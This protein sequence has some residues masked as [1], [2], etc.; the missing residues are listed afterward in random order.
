MHRRDF[1]GSLIAAAVSA[2][3]RANIGGLRGVG[4][5]G[6]IGGSA[7][8]DNFAVRAGAPMVVWAHNFE[9]A[10][11][12]NQW[13]WVGGQMSP[14]PSGSQAQWASDSTGNF[15]R[16]TVPT[17]GNTSDGWIRPMGAFAAG[18]PVGTS[19]GNGNGLTTDDPAANGT[20]RKVVWNSSNTAEAYNYR[21]SYFTNPVIQVAYPYWPSIGDTGVYDGTEFWLQVKVRISS[22]RWNTG[23]PG[24]KLIF[25]DVTAQLSDLQEVVVRSVNNT[26]SGTV[27]GYDFY[28]T[29][30]LL[31][32][33]SRG[34]YNNST[35]DATQGGGDGAFSSGTS[36]EPGGPYATSCTYGGADTAGNCWEFPSGEW[37]TL[38]FHM[39]P[40]QDTSSYT[41]TPPAGNTSG[42]PFHD[43]TIEVWKC[44]V[45]DVGYTKIFEQ[46][47]LAWFYD[48]APQSGTNG[49]T[50]Q[51]HAPAF[52]EVSFSAY[53]NG[54]NSSIGWTQD[55][56]EAIFSK[57]Y[58]APPGQTAPTWW[59]SA[60]DGQ[61]TAI[62]GGGGFGSNYQNGNRLSDVAPSPPVT[63]SGTGQSSIIETWSGGTVDYVN[64]RYF[65]VAN[66]GHGDYAGNEGYVL[67]L[68]TATPSWQRFIDPTPN[69]SITYNDSP[70]ASFAKNSDGRARSMHTSAFQCYGDY[71]IW[72]PYCNSY[73]SP[74][75]GSTPYVASFNTLNSGVAAALADNTTLAWDG[76]V[77]P[78]Q[79]W[80]IIPGNSGIDGDGSTGA[81]SFGCSC[82]DRWGH[83]VYGFG[84][85]GFDRTNTYVW[86]INTLGDA[87]G[88]GNSYLL[89]SGNPYADFRWAVCVFDLRII[90][91]ADGS[92]GRLVVFDLNNVGGSGWYTVPTVSGT[93]YY[94]G[95]VSGPFPGAFYIP[96]TRQ[97][98]V[99]D[100]PNIGNKVYALNVPT[101]ADAYGRTI[102]N[103]SGVWTWTN[104]TPGGVT[105]TF[106]NDTKP[107]NRFNG[108]EDMGDGRSALVYVGGVNA[109]TYVYKIPA[110]GL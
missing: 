106:P 80:G 65:L 1:I 91:A 89:N 86:Y 63:D 103:P 81:A 98:A 64:A 10:S 69:G 52:N 29:N 68:R 4:R 26:G 14:N 108:I 32:Y 53:M 62:A 9:S 17:G 5:L 59:T 30:P 104:S 3:A 33:T 18:Q 22:S 88:T 7:P 47:S 21:Q 99:G 92:N 55:F 39:I 46:F 90:V 11:E 42:W 109:P 77:G 57:D 72:Y 23:N 93:G 27:V 84:G 28:Q 70:G 43:T 16:I 67:N 74:S 102:Y 19:G 12:V 66:G 25:V 36:L 110:A 34:S 50:G 87:A 82:F 8:T 2:A 95:G 78:W 100:P 56:S 40:G 101:T 107:Y 61:W 71:Q 51:W 6:S 24:G 15:L 73:S 35:I 97:I 83:R 41:G 48:T 94:G 60:T 13:R 54:V 96:K 58:I 76:T 105:L 38:L 20:V 45:G 75:G 37:T 79:F 31:M 49:P 85:L 44:D